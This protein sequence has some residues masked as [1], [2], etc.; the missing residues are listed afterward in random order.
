MPLL[1][2]CYIADL[3][4]GDPEWF[5]HPVRGMGKLIKFLEKRLQKNFDNKPLLC[6]QER[7]KWI[8]RIKGMILAFIVLGVSVLL[9][10]LLIKFS[11]RSNL[12]LQN[13]VWVYLGYTTLSV[14]DLLL[15]ARAIFDELKQGR[16][17]NARSKLSH[18]VGRD[19]EGLSEEKV[20]KAA[21][22]SIAESTNDGIVGPLFY[23]S[24]GGP[25]ASIAYKAINTLDSMVGHK[26]EKYINFG[27]I[28][29]KLDDVA[30]FIPARITG[31]L[32]PISSF[33]AGK[34]FR[35]SFKIMLQD[36][37]KH[38]SPNS[39]ISEAAMAGA[40][41]VRLGGPSTYQGKLTPKPYLGE[42]DVLI[43]PL[44]INEALRISFITSLLMV[45]MGVL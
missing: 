44:L 35:R 16:L 19:T 8:G 41:R 4:F 33:I 32:I 18:I 25:V 34:G 27:W 3:I 29:A 31:M 30:N 20:I 15:K 43:S 38:P 2:Y 5:P 42:D 13:L 7:G 17:S 1:I 37:R 14:K 28:S 22:E 6:E 11:Q 45:L 24:L 36:G 40:L 9:S 26:N 23:L 21:V 39:G 10:F 12:L